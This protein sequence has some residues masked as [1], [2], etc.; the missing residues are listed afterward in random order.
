MAQTA[1]SAAA[2]TDSL[3]SHQL[4]T[5][6]LLTRTV[7]SRQQMASLQ[8]TPDVHPEAELINTII[9][10]NIRLFCFTSAAAQ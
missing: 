9:K 6:V 8:S 10:P 5:T 7:Q 2:K 3:L 1:Y 4:Y